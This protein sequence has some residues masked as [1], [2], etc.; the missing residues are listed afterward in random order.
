MQQ[1]Y[2]ILKSK[3]HRRTIFSAISLI[4]LS[5]FSIIFYFLYRINQESQRA[6]FYMTFGLNLI[7]DTSRPAQERLKA[8]L[9]ATQA[10][11]ANPFGLMADALE[12][13]Q[14]FENK[15][16]REMQLAT[17]HDSVANMIYIPAGEFIFGGFDKFHGKIQYFFL[18]GYYIDQKPVTNIDF[19]KFLND[20]GNQIEGG[21]RW[22][23]SKYG[24]IDSTVNGFVG[25][26][27]FEN[28]PVVGVTWFGA[29][30]YARSIGKRLPTEMEW[31]KAARGIYGRFY[32]WGYRFDFTRC[33][34]ASYWAGR[35]IYQKEWAEWYE[36]EGRRQSD[37]TPVDQFPTG[38]SPY[39]C[40]DM[41]GNVWEWTGTLYPG[42]VN[43]TQ[44][45]V[46]RGGA[47]S[48]A[49]E[50]IQTAFRGIDNPEEGGSINGFRCAWTPEQKSKRGL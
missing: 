48:Y 40:F 17:P 3:I 30:A 15:L 46:N 21:S 5:L 19:C 9:L 27:N 14:V 26:K 33:N 24:H 7:T 4:V 38:R 6:D 29:R 44:R 16:L 12:Q 28:H 49:V 13:L 18:D 10:A 37:T 25:Q 32:P 2:E 20:S 36:N 50:P 22:Y 34:S 42:A 23:H 45:Y 39:G 8:A 47:F 41:C 43:Q 11:E 1:N 35:N 31:E